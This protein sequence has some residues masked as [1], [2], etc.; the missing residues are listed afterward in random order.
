MDVEVGGCGRQGLRKQWPVNGRR[1]RRRIAVATAALFFCGTVAGQQQEGS[2]GEYQVKAAFLFDFAQFVEWPPGTFSDAGAPL[3]Y[4][5]LG[6]DP[7][8]GALDESLAG[9][10]IGGHPLRVKHL[11]E[12]KEA[13]TC[14]I[15]FLSADESRLRALPM[16]DLAGTGVLTVG[17]AAHFARDGGVIGFCREQ[18]KIRFEINL[19]AAERAKLKISAKLLVLAK[20]VIGAR[21]A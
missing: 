10:T 14:Q 9:K 21:G 17:E 19:D 1:R 5:T 18:N 12:L 4:C 8:G 3:T 2:A 15:L 6:G 7:F 13:R 11:K 20:S 16:G